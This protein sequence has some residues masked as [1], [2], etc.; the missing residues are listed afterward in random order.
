MIFVSFI[1]EFS[2]SFG[3]DSGRRANLNPLDD[4]TLMFI[5]GN[6]LLLLDIS[7]KEQRFLRSCSGGGIGAITVRWL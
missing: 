5:A 3:Y 4:R 2:H 6:L 7:T 1:I